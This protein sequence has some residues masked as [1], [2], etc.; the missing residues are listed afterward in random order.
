MSADLS[1]TIAGVDEMH[2]KMS[3]ERVAGAGGSILTPLSLPLIFPSLRAGRQRGGNP[4]LCRT[5]S[6]AIAFKPRYCLISTDRQLT[7]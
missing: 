1:Q 6:R 4:I 2:G 7:V 3:R 5:A